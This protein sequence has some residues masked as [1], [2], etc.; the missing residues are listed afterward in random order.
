M[1]ALICGV[2]WLVWNFIFHDF[3]PINWIE[4]KM[5]SVF[6]HE[7][8]AQEP[9]P[10]PVTSAV[11]P[12]QSAISHLMP[13]RKMEKSAPAITYQPA[14]SFSPLNSSASGTLYD[15][16]ILET[17]IAAIPPNSIVKDYPM[18][19]D[20]TMPGDLAVSRMQDLTDPDKYTMKIG[21]GT[22]KI[23]S[24]SPSHTTLTV[25][26]KNGDA[27]GG[28]L[29]GSG[30]M[31]FFWE[32][33]KTIHINEIDLETKNPSVVYQCSLIVSGSKNPLTIQCSRPEDLEHL[34][35]TMEYFIRSSRLAHDAQPAGL[36][37]PTQGL[38]FT[39]ADNVINLLWADSPA[40]KAG[41]QLGDHL[42]SLGKIT[43]EQQD[44][45]ELEKDLQSSANDNIGSLAQPNLAPRLVGSA[46]VP[47]TLFAASPAE[48]TK[49]E[50]AKNSGMTNALRPKLRKI[51]LTAS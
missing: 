48:W 3:H 28:F 41:V 49:A 32:D 13:K 26:Y 2:A 47:V 18:T 37:Y 44:K 5:E 50:I 17:E 42:W 31:N 35:S 33:V 27:L 6:H 10:E 12:V 19:P 21:G 29:D 45:N 23:L 24:V 51:L 14:V 40:D 38:R 1:V 9:T 30:Q 15:P 39:G 22:E 46:Q 36:P 43:S 7:P 11:S 20:E 16:K 8:P 34:V 4:S 25:S